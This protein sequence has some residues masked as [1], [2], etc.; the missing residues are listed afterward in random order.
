MC[1]QSFFRISFP[2]P[3]LQSSEKKLRKMISNKILPR[4]NDSNTLKM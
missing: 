2:L 1:A 4:S 3:A